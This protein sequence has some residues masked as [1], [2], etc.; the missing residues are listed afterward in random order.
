MPPIPFHSPLRCT[1]TSG[2]GGYPAQAPIAT[3]QSISITP[4]VKGWKL[5]LWLCRTRN[6]AREY[7]YYCQTVE[8]IG[9]I[10]EEYKEDPEGVMMRVFGWEGVRE[11]P[12]AA[13]DLEEL[14][15]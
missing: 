14:D 3:L 1:L 10:L 5:S 9:E 8:R 13:I 15:L 6:E 12:K 2:L 11:G 4:E 7:K